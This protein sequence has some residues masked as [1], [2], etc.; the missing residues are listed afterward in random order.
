MNARE[1]SSEQGRAARRKETQVWVMTG[2][3]WLLI[4]TAWATWL[5]AAGW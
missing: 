3:V 2:L 4:F 1:R 5:W